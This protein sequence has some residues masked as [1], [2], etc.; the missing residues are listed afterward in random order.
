LAHSDVGGYTDVVNMVINGHQ[1]SYKRDKEL[2]YRWMEM[3][4]FSDVIFR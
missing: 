2:L 1:Y 4:T 3:S